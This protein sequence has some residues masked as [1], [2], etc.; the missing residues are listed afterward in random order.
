M[1]FYEFFEQENPDDD[2]YYIEN[3]LKSIYQQILEYYNFHKKIESFFLD[4]F[5]ADGTGKKEDLYFIDSNWIEK[6]K[7]FINYEEV[8]KDID[9]GE[10]YLIENNILK[11][12]N[13]YY[14]NEISS[15]ESIDIFLQKTL[16][17]AKDFD[18]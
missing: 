11:R 3:D 8:I 16:L 12:N 10:D 15:G 1:Y 2:D 17:E 6:W 5:N 14:P 13:D 4:G 9:K 7:I 18:S